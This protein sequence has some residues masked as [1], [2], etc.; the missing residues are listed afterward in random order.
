MKF[1]RKGNLETAFFRLMTSARLRRA[2]AFFFALKGRQI[3]SFLT[4]IAII[5]VCALAIGGIFKKLKLPSLC[6][7]LVVGILLGPYV[8]DLISGDVLAISS[9][10][11]QFALIVI[12]T[13]AGLSLKLG[14]LKK[15]GRPAVLLCFVP[16]TFEIIGYI[17]F[18]PL[19]LHTTIA[20]SALAGAVMAAV[21]PAVVVPRMLKLK[22]ERYGTDKGIPQMI[23]AGA[24]CDDV[25]V[26]VLFSAFLTTVQTGDFDLNIFWK[27]PVSILLGIAL[28]LIVGFVCAKVFKK[29]ASVSVKTIVLL[30][31]SF[32]FV[33][34]ET[35]VKKYVPF[36]GLLSVISAGVM[37]NVKAENEA[38]ELSDGYSKI[39][40]FAEIIL[41]VL[42][43]AQANVSY[44]V[45]SGA[46]VIAVMFCALIFRIIGV[47]VCLIK[48]DLNFKERLFCAIAYIPKA[49][50][51][52]AIGAI[53]LSM[54]LP[55][56]EVVLTCAVLAILVTAP[57][58]AFA[59][60]LT[61][62][63]LLS[64]DTVY[65]RESAL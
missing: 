11:R 24:S 5:I 43:G 8:F 37:L 6:G 54:A 20:E 60:D 48:T 4:S 17:A 58:G 47:F 51:Q 27:V 9:D 29:T 39:W 50:V 65:I 10:L 31:L 14:D 15:V 16:A 19:I 53:P 38:K 57:L 18:A 30:A 56:G 40:T 34:L 26:I 63:R 12:L 7:M 2:S 64:C 61:Y 42:V 22:N 49:T 44:A 46:A 45:K 59:I 41:F 3:M 32:L 28:G 55:C 52:A 36:S 23:M 1:F 25:F 21:S 13:R 33:A 62:R 35:T